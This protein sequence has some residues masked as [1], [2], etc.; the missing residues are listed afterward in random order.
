MKVVINPTAIGLPSEEDKKFVDIETIKDSRKNLT[1][2]NPV[3]KF[4]AGGETT[5]PSDI[6][7]LKGIDE[8]EESDENLGHVGTQKLEEQ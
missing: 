5:V 1:L 7:E 8:D 3:G 6:G 2:T 4:E